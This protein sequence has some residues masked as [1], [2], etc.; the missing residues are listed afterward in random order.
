MPLQ[1]TLDA[2]QLR[3]FEGPHG[4]FVR[5]IRSNHIGK[6]FRPHMLK[7]VQE[8]RTGFEHAQQK[9][10]RLIGKGGVKR[11]KRDVFGHY[12]APQGK[13]DPKHKRTSNQIIKGLYWEDEDE[14]I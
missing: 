4:H 3:V 2:L 1:S 13:T 9:L 10:N 7:Q 11:V 5:F 8:R 6:R 14:D 12:K